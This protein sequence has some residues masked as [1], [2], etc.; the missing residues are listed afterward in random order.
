MEL[1]DSNFSEINTNINYKFYYTKVD[2]STLKVKMIGDVRIYKIIQ[3]ITSQIDTRNDHDSVILIYDQF[4]HRITLVMINKMN[5]IV[6]KQTKIDQKN[7]KFIHN[8]QQVHSLTFSAMKL[9]YGQ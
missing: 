2:D 1:I 6:L 5:Q 9:I 3:E 4:N 7:I 8:D